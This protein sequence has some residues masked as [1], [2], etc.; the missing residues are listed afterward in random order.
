MLA[1]SPRGCLRLF[2]CGAG[3]AALLITAMPPT[4]KGELLSADT[5]YIAHGSIQGCGEVIDIGGGEVYGLIAD[6]QYAVYH[7]TAFGLDFPGL[8]IYAYQFLSHGPDYVNNFG[9]GI[10]DGNLQI[11]NQGSVH[12]GQGI[13]PSGL[14]Q[15]QLGDHIVHW[16]FYSPVVDVGQYSN[17][18]YFTS[19]YAPGRAPVY[20]DAG[21]AVTVDDPSIEPFS[22]VPEMGTGALMLV[23]GT[24]FL[25]AKLAGA[26]RRNRTSIY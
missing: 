23:A 5:S 15:W 2:L 24:A 20:I 7:N 22:P 16:R 21:W 3:V 19:P 1:S 25:L 4:A 26:I 13:T 12:D 8:Y 18:L 14:D 11:A 6:V 9:M 10:N 17:I